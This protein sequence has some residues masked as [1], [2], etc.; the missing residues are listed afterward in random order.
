MGILEKARIEFI[1]ICNERNLDFTRTVAV[2]PLSPHDAIGDAEADF[3]IKKGKEYVIE[4][5]FNKAHGQAFTGIAC[6][7]NGTLEALL[8]L[9]LSDIRNRGIFVASMNAV[10]RSLKLATGTNHCLDEDPTNCGPEIAQQLKAKF[11]AKRFGLVGL[12]PA[13]LKALVNHFT[14]EFVRVVD[15]NPDNIGSLKS[16]IEVW[17]GQTDLPCLV[18][19]SEVGLATGSSIV[20][21]TIDKI[22]R[23]FKDDNKTLVFF[24]NT[25]SG[26]ATLLDLDRLCP[27]GR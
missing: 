23:C 7:W 11:G 22:I 18:E 24:G 6:Q 2:R 16:G 27:F 9:D 8:S 26:T 1:Q 4:A 25:I 13:I 17:D 15:L 10:L 14:R 12:Q 19:W 21:G 5:E 3:V 20:N